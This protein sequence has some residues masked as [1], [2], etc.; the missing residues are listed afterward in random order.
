MVLLDKVKDAAT[1]EW[2]I[3][4]A[5]E[6]G[7]S[8]NALVLQIES[9]LHERQGKAV[10]NF[11]RTLPQPQSDLAG[12]LL[13]DPYNFD[14]LTLAADARERELETGLLAHV[15]RFLLEL[16]VGFALVGSQYPLEVGGEDFYLDQLFYHCKLHCYFV[17]DLT[18]EEFRPEFAGKMNFYLS[19]VDDL[20]CDRAAAE[21]A[22]RR[23]RAA[24]P[25]QA[26]RG[27][28]VRDPAGGGPAAR[29]GRLTADGRP[30]GG[31][32]GQTR[33]GGGRTRGCDGR[34]NR[35]TSGAEESLRHDVRT[36]ELRDRPPAVGV[37]GAEMRNAH[38][39]VPEGK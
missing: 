37:T 32:V 22:D 34:L 29:V 31:G 2:Y 19:A 11:D 26:D 23:V 13:K 17:I 33:P 27:G 8:R 15:L 39:N 12:D 20:V 1:R 3:R 30:V 14:F 24:R 10:H 9:G 4:K 28:R 6:H 21:P 35:A 5:V 16:G 25:G 18:M 7:W 36:P 38:A